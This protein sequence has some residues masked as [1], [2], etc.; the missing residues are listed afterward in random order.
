NHVGGRGAGAGGIDR[1]QELF[2]NIYIDR[3]LHKVQKAPRRPGPSVFPLV[4]FHVEI[5]EDVL[6]QLDRL[7]PG[8]LA[9]LFSLRVH[10][11]E[12][13]ELFGEELLQADVVLVR[14]VAVEG[15]DLALDGGQAPEDAPD[16]SEGR[17]LFAGERLP[18]G[19]GL[20]QVDVGDEGLHLHHRP[21]PRLTDAGVLARAHLVQLADQA[22][23]LRLGAQVRVG[24][25]LGLEELVPHGPRLLAHRLDPQD[26]LVLAQVEGVGGVRFL[27]QVQVLEQLV[28]FLHHLL[29]VVPD[30]RAPADVQGIQV[31]GEAREDAGQVPA[32][33]AVVHAHEQGDQGPAGLVHFGHDRVDLG[34]GRV[35]PVGERQGRLLLHAALQDLLHGAHPGQRVVPG[36]PQGD[37]P[38]RLHVREPQDD[39]LDP[40][41]ELVGDAVASA[42][43]GSDLLLHQGLGLLEDRLD[44]QPAR[45]VGVLLQLLQE[46]LGFLGRPL[47]RLLDVPSAFRVDGVDLESPLEQQLRKLRQETQEWNQ[48]FWAT[49]NLAFWK[50]K[51]EF[52]YRRLKAK[53]LEVRDETGQKITL[54]AEEMADFYKEF[55]SK[56]FKKHMNYNRDWYKRNF[57]I[58]FFMGKVAVERIWR[59]LGRK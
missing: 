9:L 47:P 37:L 59:R 13:E 45:V 19:Q 52:I 57:T 10:R 3:S 8:R 2:I 5:A 25:V 50:E 43:E 32:G 51:E 30:L 22:L 16:G 6:G 56:N 41:F 27:L 14:P 46:P 55:L 1:L 33:L 54:S 35:G 49:Q 26:G 29:P 40:L 38:P 34:D 31:G 36:L 23:Q 48:R 24:R 44:L 12:G 28:D 20:L 21:P 15:E 11:V 18:L 58:T 53:G 17:V 7:F 39:V 42:V 4:G